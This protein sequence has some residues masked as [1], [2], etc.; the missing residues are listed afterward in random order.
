MQKTLLLI[1]AVAVANGFSEQGGSRLTLASHGR[2]EYVIVTGAA[3]ETPER[4]AAQ[5]LQK[6]IRLISGST[7][8]I[9]NQGGG[10]KRI[11]IGSAA[12]SIAGLDKGGVDSFVVRIND[13]RI[14]LA[15]ASPRG[16]LFSVYYFLEKYLGCG[17]LVPGDEYVP[18]AD[19]VTVPAKVEDSE[20]P[21][22]AYRAISLFPYA[23]SQIGDRLRSNA[24]FTYA[25][26]Q[27]T[28]DRIDWAA[29][30]RLNYVHPCVNEAGPALWEKVNS[31]EQIVPEVTKRGLGLHYGGHSYFAWLPPEKYFA[32]HP[33]YYTAVQ[34]GKPQSLNLANPEVAEVMAKNI[35]EFLE[36]NPE[37]S[38]VTVWMND[39]PAVCT[40]PGCLEMEGTL[41]LSVSN[42]P[43][44]YPPMLSFSNASLKFTNAVAKI[45]SKTH[46][47]VVV[48]H[49][50][51]NE[52]ID[53]PTNVRPEP[54]VLVAF[55]PIQRA[56]FR[57]GAEAGYFRPLKDPE[58]EVNRQYLA[59]IRKWMALSRNFYVW[60]YYSL[61]WT[62]GDNRPRWQFPV[63]E[64]IEA[65]LKFY[66]DELR[67]KHVSSEIADWHEENMYV[68]T[69][70]AWNPDLS[71]REAL[72]D[73]CRRSYGPAA[74]EMREHWLVLQSAKGDWFHR[75]A[76]CEGLLRK[77]LAKAETTDIRR[78]INRIAELWQ[79]SECHKEGD[80]VGA[81]KK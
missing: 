37:I 43:D 69:K 2:S 64:T 34:N 10:L 68:Y 76:E 51:Y 18:R 7:L 58:N 71:W 30:N 61:W 74:D 77:A 53:A 54:N 12:G 17:W 14:V 70:L 60:D 79:E 40:T 8:P 75:R 46:P 3:P 25:L 38:I 57:I 5:E 1:F 26:L 16:T 20:S 42:P 73:F 81:C 33:E 35:A 65:D 80:P 63:M 19:E 13:G 67:L 29:K 50:A 78:R 23:D 21:A 59:E 39:A 52:L 9:Q 72:A 4:F 55:A 47:E 6:Y 62:L 11:L 22:F 28:K 44:S 49:L 32:S 15:G 48:N 27:V 66:R 45:L 36:K 56:Q 31:R 24:L 41:R